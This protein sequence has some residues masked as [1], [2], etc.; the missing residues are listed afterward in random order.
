MTEHKSHLEIVF[1][2][3]VSALLHVLVIA[4]AQRYYHQEFQQQIRVSF[5][6]PE[7]QRRFQPPLA[8]PTPF[9]HA[10][11]SASMSQE[12]LE[13]LLG[14]DGVPASEPEVDGQQTSE[15]LFSGGRQFS[16]RSHGVYEE[17]G[18]QA[19]GDS[20][21]K[22]LLRRLLFHE[23]NEGLPQEL[24]P[25]ELDAYGRQHTVVIV[26]PE[27]RKLKRAQ[28]HLPVYRNAPAP[29]PCSPYFGGQETDEVMDLLSRGFRVPRS[30][31]LSSQIHW[32]QLGPC[33]R[34]SQP[35]QDG[36]CGN[37][38]PIHTFPDR[39][40]RH[41]LTYG[42]MKEYPVLFLQVI[43]V[44]STEATARYLIEGGFVMASGHQLPLLQQALQVRVGARL[45]PVVVEL[46]HPLFHSFYDITAYVDLTPPPTNCPAIG[47]LPG[48][49]LDGRLIAVIE[50]RFNRNYPCRANKLFVNVLAY[51]LIQP[52]PMGGRY[53]SRRN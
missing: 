44:E 33:G 42:E 2:L 31:P 35:V 48:L 6:A 49:E 14:G 13:E 15:D 37:E 46:G 36:C 51:A 7:A 45:K 22:E 43:D 28:L 41:I 25:V 11:P 8:V 9:G 30:T 23:S 47:P 10:Q 5:S 50:P 52:S 18:G 17:T 1:A 34:R 24:D 27:T 4:V 19:T 12:R 16:E 26:D 32:F 3:I 38:D 40:T 39:P 20:A 29:G 21:E 53:L